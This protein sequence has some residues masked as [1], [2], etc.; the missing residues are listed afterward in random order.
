MSKITFL[1][2][3]G[4]V[5]LVIETDDGPSLL[6]TM[7]ADDALTMAD[8]LGDTALQAMEASVH[9]A[10]AVVQQARDESRGVRQS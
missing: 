8:N 5:R 10:A 3:P 4:S 9:A 2:M 6:L 7:P 1:Y